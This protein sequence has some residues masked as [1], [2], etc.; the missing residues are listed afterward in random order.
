VLEAVA[1]VGL[2]PA[3]E[4][5]QGLKA[6]LALALHPIEDVTGRSSS[7]MDPMET[8][9]KSYA[10]TGAEIEFESENK[11]QWHLLFVATKN[12]EILS[13]KTTWQAWLAR[14]KISIRKMRS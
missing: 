12:R 14:G 5:A 7:R 4:K 13:R 8:K 1:L 2:E 11:N 6:G 10:E 3:P 9:N